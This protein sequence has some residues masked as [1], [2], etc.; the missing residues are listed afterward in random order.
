MSTRLMED[1]LWLESI[2]EQEYTEYI[3]LQ[4]EGQKSIIV[5]DPYAVNLKDIIDA[6][7]QDHILVRVR[8]PFWGRGNLQQYI[9]KINLEWKG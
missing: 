6:K 7:D 8:R 5:V 3:V 4:I 2:E 9:Y 1:C